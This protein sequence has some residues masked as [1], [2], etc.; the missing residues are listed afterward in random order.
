MFEWLINEVKRMLGMGRL[1]TTQ[2]VADRARRQAESTL[3]Q[4]KRNVADAAEAKA[5]EMARRDLKGR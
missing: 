2:E 4:T 3:H 1:D 5:R